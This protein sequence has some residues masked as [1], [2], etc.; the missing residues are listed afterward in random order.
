METFLLVLASLTALALLA[1]LAEL[2][3]GNHLLKSLREV[4]RWNGPNPPTV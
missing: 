2:V 4:A 1:T 3:W